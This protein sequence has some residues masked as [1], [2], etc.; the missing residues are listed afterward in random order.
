M[1]PSPFQS[2]NCTVSGQATQLDSV[3]MSPLANTRSASARQCNEDRIVNQSSG[4]MSAFRSHAFQWQ[5]VQPQS[6]LSVAVVCVTQSRKH[7]VGGENVSPRIISGVMAGLL[8]YQQSKSK[9]I[10][11]GSRTWLSSAAQI[12]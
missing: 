12:Q 6:S 2:T 7:R 9:S 8:T 5:W 4:H 1:S 11:R 10:A 3:G